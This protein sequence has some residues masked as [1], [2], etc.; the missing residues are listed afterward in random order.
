MGICTFLGNSHLLKSERNNIFGCYRFVIRA[1]RVYHCSL[2][3][4]IHV[5]TWAPPSFT[6]GCQ[7]FLWYTKYST[8][9]KLVIPLF[10]ICSIL[11][12]KTS[13]NSLQSNCGNLWY[14][15]MKFD[16][17]CDFEL[18]AFKAGFRAANCIYNGPRDFVAKLYVAAGQTTNLGFP[19]KAISKH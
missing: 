12:A 9:L 4:Q 7:C 5:A 8:Q 17:F 13:Q 14:V 15:S 18:W 3:S 19:A 1:P 2:E 16:F 11:Y 10:V 6:T